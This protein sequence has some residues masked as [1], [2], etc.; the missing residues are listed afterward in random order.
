MMQLLIANVVG[1]A[2]QMRMRNG[3]RAESF[4]LRKSAFDP[5]L[6]VNMIGRSGF[7]LA[8]QI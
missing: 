4:L 1:Y 3:K 7:D 2:A 6:V 5:L 8:D